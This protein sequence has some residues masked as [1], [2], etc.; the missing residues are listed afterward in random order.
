[1]SVST[2]EGNSVGSELFGATAHAAVGTWHVALFTASPGSGGSGTNEVT[3]GSYARVAVTNNNTNFP[4]TAALAGANGT[5]IAFPT[6]TADWGTVTH[7][8]LCASTTEGTSDVRHYG[9]LTSP[10]LVLSGATPTFAAGA[11]TWSLA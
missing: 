5:A 8:G 2:T 11:L 9:A 10:F 6:A 3:G 7:V 4:A 1:M